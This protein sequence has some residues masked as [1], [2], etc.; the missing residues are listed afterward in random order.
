MLV[1]V[2]L[3]ASGLVLRNQIQ[4][5]FGTNEPS[6]VINQTNAY[7][8][9]PDEVMMQANKAVY[10]GKPVLEVAELFEAGANATDDKTVKAQYYM[11][12]ATFLVSNN[13]VQA[14]IEA[15]EKNRS[16]VGDSLSNLGLLAS[17]RETNGEYAQAAELYE[18]ALALL[19][20]EDLLGSREYYEKKVTEMS[21]R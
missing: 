5:F 15:A 6:A 13:Q 7:V 8:G 16:L 14:A 21:Q 11:R 12:K 3:L 20:E 18:Q 17:L 1:L 10:E 19:P 2:L 4:D 9:S